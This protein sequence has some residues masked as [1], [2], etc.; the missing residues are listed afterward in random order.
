MSVVTKSLRKLHVART[1]AKE[2]G[3]IGLLIRG[4]EFI[5]KKRAKINPSHGL[6]FTVKYKDVAAADFSSPL[7]TWKGSNRTSLRITWVMP[8]PGKGSGGHINIFR[9]IKFA[10]EAGHTCRI[11]LYAD[12]GSAP[13]AAIRDQ[14]GDSY[15]ETQA[16][17]TMEWLNDQEIEDMDALFATSWETAYATYNSKAR[18]KR[19]YF[20]QDFEPHFFP[21]GSMHAFAENTY[22]FGFYGITAGNWLATKLRNEYQMATESFDFGAD[23]SLYRLTNLG[24]R[25]EIFFYARPYT[26]RRGFEMGIVALDIFHKKHPEYTINLVGWDVSEYKIPFPYV[27]LKTL[28]VGELSDLY[29]RCAAG[30]VMSMTNMSLLPLEMLASGTIPVVN[31]GEN[32]RQVSDN[33]YIAYSPN[34]PMS[35]ANTLSAVVS[36][37]NLPKYATQ[38]SKSVADDLWQQSGMKF[39]TILE[40]EVRKK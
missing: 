36:K 37:Q 20:I 17:N 18:G 33:P 6:S 31:D 30:L 13:I 16:V 21:I 26:A 32:N 38:A 1:I 3:A 12:G 39:I 28:E 40:R 23:K 5:E 35:L 29:N 34:D 8:P 14:M 27:N 24:S 9:F 22:R 2:R 19:F 10:E 25:K 7:P 11:Y 15:P 4:L